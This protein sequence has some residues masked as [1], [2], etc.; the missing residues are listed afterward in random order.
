VTTSITLELTTCESNGYMIS[1]I[2][3]Y[4]FLHASLYSHLCYFINF[5]LRRLQ[6]LYIGK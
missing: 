6:R 3:R 2:S 4:Y 1:P 5:R